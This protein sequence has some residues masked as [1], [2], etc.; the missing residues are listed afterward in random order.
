M[1]IN[2]PM[3]FRSELS[4][5]VSK[6]DVSLLLSTFDVPGQIINGAMFKFG[7]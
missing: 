4:V 7:V 2:Y 6:V 5:V 3:N 1:A